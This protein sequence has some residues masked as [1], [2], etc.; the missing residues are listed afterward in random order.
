MH[1]F[2]RFQPISSLVPNIAC[3]TPNNAFT[4]EYC[5]YNPEYME[6]MHSPQQHKVPYLL[7]LMLNDFLTLQR[8]HR[9]NAIQTQHKV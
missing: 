5:M 1:I 2:D 4:T 9:A 8:I 6:Q 3:T 7:S